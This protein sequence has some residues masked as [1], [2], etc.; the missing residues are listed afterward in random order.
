MQQL[1]EKEIEVVL[2]ASIYLPVKHVS[3][4]YEESMLGTAGEGDADHERCR[5]KQL[6]EKEMLAS[7]SIGKSSQLCVKHGINQ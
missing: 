3:P 2:L 4:T 1:Q 6:Q 7:A 5:M